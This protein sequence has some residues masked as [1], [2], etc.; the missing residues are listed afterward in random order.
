MKHVLVSCKLRGFSALEGLIHK[1]VFKVYYGA[2]LLFSLM[3][4]FVE[5]LIKHGRRVFKLSVAGMQNA[6]SE[7]FV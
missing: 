4:G 1:K 5:I 3:T 6:M 2:C 7:L